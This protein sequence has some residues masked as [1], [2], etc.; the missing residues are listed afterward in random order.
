MESQQPKVRKLTVAMER[1]QGVTNFTVNP[2]S[3]AA[4]LLRHVASMSRSC[5]IW[6]RITMLQN[7]QFLASCEKSP[8]MHRRG[9]VDFHG[10]LAEAFY[11]GR[12]VV[13]TP[14]GNDVKSASR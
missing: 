8:P 1:E 3:L 2:T 10:D 12:L 5:A 9:I 13:R 11:P 4:S 7:V 6:L 14:L